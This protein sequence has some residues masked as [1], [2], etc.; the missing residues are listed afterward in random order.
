MICCSCRI[1]LAERRLIASLTAVKLQKNKH[2]LR[3]LIAVG[4][5]S[6]PLFLSVRGRGPGT[7]QERSKPA[8]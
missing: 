3:F 6:M 5:G 7:D 4:T 1:H 2:Y 8:T